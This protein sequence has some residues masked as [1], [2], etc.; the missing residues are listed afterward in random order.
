MLNSGK[1]NCALRDK[2][3]NI[4]TLVLSKKHFW[5]KQKTITQVKWSVPYVCTEE[6]QAKFD[7]HI[8]TLHIAMIKETTFMWCF[9][10]INQ[11]KVNFIFYKQSTSCSSLYLIIFLVK[12]FRTKKIT[13]IVDTLGLTMV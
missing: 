1:K 10:K 13:Q 7:T 2:K 8:Y 4:L 11:G 5:T 12:I 9:H 6:N 3:I